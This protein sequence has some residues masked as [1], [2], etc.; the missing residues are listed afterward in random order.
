MC[1]NMYSGQFTNLSAVLNNR[2]RALAWIKGSSNYPK[3]NGIVKFYQTRQG[4]IVASEVCGLPDGEGVCK[5]GVFAFHIHEG[6]SCTGNTEDPFANALTHYDKYG[7]EHPY[8]SGDMPPLF[9]NNGYAVSVFL[10]DRFSIDE[11]IGKAVIIHSGVDDFTSQPAGNAG[12]KI[13][14]GVIAKCC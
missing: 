7:N 8:H 3:I 13:A 6:R 2:P 10:T 1:N 14:C 11:I 12:K 9:G 4:V 5:N